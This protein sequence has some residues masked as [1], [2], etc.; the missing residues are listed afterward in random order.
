MQELLDVQLEEVNG[1]VD[2]ELSCDLR[3]H[4]AEH[5]GPIFAREESQRCGLAAASTP[6]RP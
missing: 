1:H 3:V 6:R 5:A 2:L 4:L